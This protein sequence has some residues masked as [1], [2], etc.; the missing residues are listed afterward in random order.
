MIMFL[1][2]RERA[3]EALFVR[4]QELAFGAHARR[5]K[6]FGL[7]V[8]QMSGLDEEPAQRYA[9]AVVLED[10]PHFRASAVLAR[11]TRDLERSGRVI[12]EETLAIALAQSA[13]RAQEDVLARRG[14]HLCC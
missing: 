1:E 6:L 7:W 14:T 8:A 11:V 9:M 3:E 5:N 13:D 4:R 2:Q 10:F 12:A